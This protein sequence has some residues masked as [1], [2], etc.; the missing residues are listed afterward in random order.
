MAQLTF[1][2]SLTKKIYFASDSEFYEALGFLCNSNNR[3][4]LV[5]ERNDQQGAWAHQ[6]VEWNFS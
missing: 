2:K 5:L 4:K 6:K 3:I 1:G